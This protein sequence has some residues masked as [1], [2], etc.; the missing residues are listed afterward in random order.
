M[1]GLK[2]EDFSSAAVIT[3][4]AAEHGAAGKP[5]E[6]NKFVRSGTV[7][8]FTIGFFGGQ[9]KKFRQVCGNGV[10]RH[11]GED[12]FPIVRLPPF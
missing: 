2:I 12:A 4:A 7:E 5:T 1:T 9:I 8:V 11:H 10:S 3:A 6:E